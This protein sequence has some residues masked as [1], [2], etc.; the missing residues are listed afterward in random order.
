MVLEKEIIQFME[1]NMK[2]NQETKV[3]E[4]IGPKG[5]TTPTTSTPN[6]ISKSLMQNIKRSITISILE[7]PM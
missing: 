5:K 6:P 7:E 2:T 4:I 1:G 3:W